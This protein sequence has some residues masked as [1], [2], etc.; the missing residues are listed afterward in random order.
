MCWLVLCVPLEHRCPLIKPKRLS[1]NG[2]G[3]AWAKTL[4]PMSS[5]QN[6]S[7]RIRTQRKRWEPKVSPKGTDDITTI[8]I[9]EEGWDTVKTYSS[10][11]NPE[12]FWKIVPAGEK[13]FK[14]CWQVN[15]TFPNNE[16]LRVD[17]YFRK[18]STSTRS[19]NLFLAFC[20][21]ASF[22]ILPLISVFKSLQML[23]IPDLC[24]CGDPCTGAMPVF[25]VSS[26]F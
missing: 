6:K 4:E 3:Y 17:Q 22:F 15:A 18:S 16:P 20:R 2:N 23:T 9:C 19:S 7:E 1:Q 5:M 24:V 12:A 13:I 21:S 11:R 14:N 25:A 8:P 26:Q 10:M